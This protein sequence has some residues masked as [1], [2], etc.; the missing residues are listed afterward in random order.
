MNIDKLN[1]KI[2]KIF[3][4]HS[5]LNRDSINALEGAKIG[6]A[7]EFIRSK[8]LHNQLDE[9]KNFLD[10]AKINAVIVFTGPLNLY[11]HFNHIRLP[12]HF[13]PGPF[14]YI[15][16]PASSYAQLRYMYQHNFI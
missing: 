9:F 8:K 11:H 1:K 10:S 5:L 3:Q 4:A 14:E 7:E 2:H 12:P 16:S 15:I 13:N 6:I